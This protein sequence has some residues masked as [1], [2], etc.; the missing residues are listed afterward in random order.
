M[1]GHRC[2][3]GLLC[4]CTCTA[5]TAG[6]TY[7]VITGGKGKG[8]GK[9]KGGKGKGTV[10]TTS[11]PIAAEP[12]KSSGTEDTGSEVEV[13]D[14][15]VEVEDAPTPAPAPTPA[16]AP[17]PFATESVLAKENEQAEEQAQQLQAQ[18]QAE[19]QAQ[20]QARV[21]RGETEST[22]EWADRINADRLAREAN[23]ETARK[24]GVKA[25][26]VKDAQEDCVYEGTRLAASRSP[27]AATKGGSVFDMSS[28]HKGRTMHRLVK[29]DINAEFPSSTDIQN[30]FPRTPCENDEDDCLFVEASYLTTKGTRPLLQGGSEHHQALLPQTSTGV[31]CR[32]PCVFS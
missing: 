27:D 20:L 15:E 26:E 2:G 25:Q 9:G 24:A 12:D 23:A 18:Q 8:K 16:A 14:E 11:A 29:S 22:L 19:E 13:E 30:A 6:P 1:L 5:C 3:E 7:E 10:S 32:P 31:L 17:A 4:E 28:F 21:K